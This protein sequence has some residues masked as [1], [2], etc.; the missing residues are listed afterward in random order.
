MCHTFA[1]IIFR[2]LGIE[3]KYSNPTHLD[4]YTRVPIP[5]PGKCQVRIYG[6]CSNE[7]DS[8]VSRLGSVFTN[9]YKGY[10]TKH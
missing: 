5:E 2:V 4:L 10:R 1:P 7:S 3:P 9:I 6:M 8:S